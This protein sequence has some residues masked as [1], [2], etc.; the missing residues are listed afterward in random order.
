MAAAT[1]GGITTNGVWGYGV[2]DYPIILDLLDAAGVTWKVY[3]V[4]DSVPF[5]NTDN[6]FVFWERYAHDNRTRGSKGGFLNDARKGQLPQVSWIIPQLRARLGRA[7]ARR[8][9]GGD[10]HPGGVDNSAAGVAG[11]RNPRPT[12]R[13]TTST[14]ATSS[15]CRRRSSTPTG[16]ESASRPG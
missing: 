5:G 1:S 7:P 8:R 16:L 12:S 13:P 2:F 9:H 10:G 6:V 11:C 4:W 14:A 3:N 15:T